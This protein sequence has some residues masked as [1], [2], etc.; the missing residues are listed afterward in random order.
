MDQNRNIFFL[1][2]RDLGQEVVL[3]WGFHF[4]IAKEVSPHVVTITEHVE[5]ELWSTFSL[6]IMP[7]VPLCWRTAS[8]IEAGGREG[9]GREP[10]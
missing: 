1:C 8:F 2:T 5:P 3:G 4:G 10:K 6:E 9:R 7:T